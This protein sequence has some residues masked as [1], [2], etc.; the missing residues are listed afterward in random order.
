MDLQQIKDTINKTSF[1]NESLAQINNILNIAIERG[2][3]YQDE[4]IKLISIIKMEI[5]TNNI[6]ADALEDVILTLQSFVN[7]G[8]DVETL[9]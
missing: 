5:T 7:N 9:K 3:L 1:S 4:K 2:F 8:E 6:E